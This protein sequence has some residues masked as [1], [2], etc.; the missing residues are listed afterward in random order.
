MFSWLY[1][2]D[3]YLMETLRPELSIGS[4]KKH[5]TWKATLL[6]YTDISESMKGP[7]IKKNMWKINF[8][9]IELYWILIL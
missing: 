9:L 7:S 3:Y 2:L 8:M 6:L 1:S 5:E 4:P